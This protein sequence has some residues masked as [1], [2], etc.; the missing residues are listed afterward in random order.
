MLAAVASASSK[1]A[2]ASSIR[3]ARRWGVGE[4]RERLRQVHPGAD[5]PH[6]LDRGLQ[7]A[8]SFF[9][10]SIG[11]ECP[12]QMNVRVELILRQLIT[13]GQPLERL[14]TLERRPVLASQL[15]EK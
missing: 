14:G 8:G 6:G 10:S 12:S 3:P 2:P 9:M 4:K 7:Q 15:I 1:A 11:R 13:I 5:E